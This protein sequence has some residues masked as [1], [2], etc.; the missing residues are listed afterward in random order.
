MGEGNGVKRGIMS[1]LTHFLGS[2]REAAVVLSL[3]MSV[4]VSSHL[5]INTKRTYRFP[6]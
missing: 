2:I 5:L 3:I 1:P 6:L 4:H